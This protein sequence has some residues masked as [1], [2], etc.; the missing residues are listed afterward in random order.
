MTVF[1]L[2]IFTEHWFWSKQLFSFSIFVISFQCLLTLNVS[3]EKSA[4]SALVSFEDNLYFFLFH[5]QEPIFVFSV[6]KFTLMSLGE[7]FFFLDEIYL[8]FGN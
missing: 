3:L 2:P 8:A 6:F 7:D 4:L 1:S 5:F